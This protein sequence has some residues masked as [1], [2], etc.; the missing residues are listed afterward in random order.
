[1]RMC[2]SGAIQFSFYMLTCTFWSG[3]HICLFTYSQEVEPSHEWI[4]E[5]ALALYCCSTVLTSDLETGLVSHGLGKARARQIN[6]QRWWSGTFIPLRKMASLRN[7]WMFSFLRLR[8]TLSC[9]LGDASV[10]AS[11]ALLGTP[12][13]V[14]TPPSHHKA[15][16][17]GGNA[18]LSCYLLEHRFKIV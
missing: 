12:V 4:F 7:I 18:G 1:M 6:P 14:A 13:E 11:P 15:K 8:S 17:S 16:D 3:L 10:Q 9:V 5:N 2:K